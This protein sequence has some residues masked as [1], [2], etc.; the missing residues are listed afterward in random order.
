MTTRSPLV[1]VIVPVYNTEEYL[2]DCVESVLTQTYSSLEVLLVDDGSTDSSGRRCDAYAHSDPRVRVIHQ[3]NAGLSQAR[4]TGLKHAYGQWVLFLD[5]DDWVAPDCLSAL[6]DLV[7]DGEAQLALCGTARVSDPVEAEASAGPVEAQRVSGDDFLRN[8]ASFQPVH[9]VSACAKL[10]GRELLEDVRF[11]PGRLHEDVFVTHVILHRATRVAL[12]R[13]VLHFYRQRPG[14]ITAGTMSL[15]SASDK[16]RGH[17]SRA[18]DLEGFGLPDVAGLEFRRGL[19]WHL[20]VARLI[21]HRGDAKAMAELAEQRAL[22]LQGQGRPTLTGRT[23]LTV[24]AYSVA[25][26]TVAWLFAAALHLT[27]R[28]M[29]THPIEG[30]GTP[31]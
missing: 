22:I 1:S 28:G 23:R 17:L 9:P 11:P 13:R 10:I 31:T 30:E 16:A 21:R 6:V 26:R 29:G 5:S 20:R 8:P 27:T 14:S 4:N 7:S 12:T 25:P 18:R 2:T 15:R 19:G 24:S 3:A